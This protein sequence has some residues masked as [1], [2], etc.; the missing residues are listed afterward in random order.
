VKTK[1]RPPSFARNTPL[2]FVDA[3]TVVIVE[4][5]KAA[6]Y[7]ERVTTPI[8]Q[9]HV[10]NIRHLGVIQPVV[11]R[12]NG[13]AIEIV[14]GKARVRWC[15]ESSRLNRL[16]GQPPIKL[17]VILRPMD[18]RTALEVAAAENAIRVVDAPMAKARK[19][20]RLIG[21]GFTQIEVARIFGVCNSAICQWLALLRLT[22]DLQAAVDRGEVRSDVARRL[23]VL[24]QS[25]QA[26]AVEA[27]TAECEGRSHQRRPEAG[28]N[29]VST[30]KPQRRPARR[31]YF[32]TGDRARDLARYWVQVDRQCLDAR[33]GVLLLY[34]SHDPETTPDDV[35]KAF[36]GLEP[37]FASP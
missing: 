17:P 34:L 21:R 1:S 35:V 28:G 30:G 32:R 15:R 11:G 24:P 5:E 27:V 19:A 33:F 29:G 37:F 8:D 10:D 7:D 12:R 26:A 18:D 13:T 6:L 2:I 4:D 3:E 22:P 23:T 14:A 36:P 16:A 9:A 25:E 31:E 20:Q